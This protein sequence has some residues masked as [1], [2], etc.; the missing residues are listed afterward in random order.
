MDVVFE[1]AG[2]NGGAG[3][4]FPMNEGGRVAGKEVVL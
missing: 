3:D 2:S 4:S 1:G